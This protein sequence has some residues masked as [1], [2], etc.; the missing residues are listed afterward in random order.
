MKRSH[1]PRRSA[2]SDVR[3]MFSLSFCLLIATVIVIFIYLV[4]VKHNP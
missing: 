4:F 3:A 1:L 2:H